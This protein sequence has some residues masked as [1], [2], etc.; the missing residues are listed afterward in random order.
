[1]VFAQQVTGRLVT[2]SGMTT[3]PVNQFQS[4][5]R[6]FGGKIERNPQ[7]STSWWLP[8]IVPTEG[9]PNVLQTITNN[10]SSLF[11]LVSDMTPEK[12][13]EELKGTGGKML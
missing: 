12:V 7:K 11:V 6:P 9:A 1:M 5:V 4:P 3:I 13:L 2:Q 8:L 10:T